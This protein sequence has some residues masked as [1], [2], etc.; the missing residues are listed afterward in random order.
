MTDT[1]RLD[2]MILHKATVCCVEDLYYVEYRGGKGPY[3]VEEGPRRDTAR[4]AIDAAI[5][6]QFGWD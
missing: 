2:W 6:F 1:E 4:E 3:I 5:N